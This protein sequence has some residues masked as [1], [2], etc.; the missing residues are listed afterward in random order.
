MSWYTTTF[1]QPTAAHIAMPS[2]RIPDTNR[3]PQAIQHKQIFTIT[4]VCHLAVGMRDSNDCHD[5]SR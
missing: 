2:S 3:K 4:N 1:E 5:I